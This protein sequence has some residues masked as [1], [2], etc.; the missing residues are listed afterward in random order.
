[1]NVYKSL[2]TMSVFVVLM[3]SLIIFLVVLPFALLGAF[4]LYIF[5]KIGETVLH[6][7]DDIK[8]YF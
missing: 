8:K 5:F 4:L 6:I 3:I 1:M 7:P 2:E